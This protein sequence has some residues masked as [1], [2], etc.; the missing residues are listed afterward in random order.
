[1]FK[2][3]SVSRINVNIKGGYF[4][5]DALSLSSYNFYRLYGANNIVT[6]FVIDF[7]FL[8]TNFRHSIT[9]I[10]EYQGPNF[11]DQREN[12]AVFINYLK[13]FIIIN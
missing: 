5:H 10:V 2:T 8:Q 3:S 12:V 9:N 1:L 6:I 7:K 11:H 13:G 4:F